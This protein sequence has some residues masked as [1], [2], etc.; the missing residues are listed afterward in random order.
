MAG[1]FV[2]DNLPVRGPVVPSTETYDAPQFTGYRGK[3]IEVEL[4]I[5]SPIETLLLGILREHFVPM[6]I[7]VADQHQEDVDLPVILVR[8]S[9]A[10]GANANIPK[11]TRF[12]RSSRVTVSVITEGV[13]ADS[14]AASLIQAAQQVLLMAWRKQQ[15]IDGAGSI[16]AIDQFSEPTRVTDVQSASNIV[17]YPSLARGQVRYEQQ[18]NIIV[19]PDSLMHNNPFLKSSSQRGI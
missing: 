8:S 6:G 7:T 4:P 1:P 15:V 3:E 9:R 17:Q 11:D 16:S 12:I 10:G 18:L 19:R 2:P 13:D 14:L 5:F